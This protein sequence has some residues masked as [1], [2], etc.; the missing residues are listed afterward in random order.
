MAAHVGDR[1]G[2]GHSLRVLAE[3]ISKVRYDGL[4]LSHLM[5]PKA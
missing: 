4:D 3:T 5:G 2:V 1:Y